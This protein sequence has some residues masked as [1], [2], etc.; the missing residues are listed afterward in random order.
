MK[1]SLDTRVQ[2]VELPGR[3]DQP[4]RPRST[5]LLGAQA[6]ATL[7]LTDLPAIRQLL[8]GVPAS[9]LVSPDGAQARLPYQLSWD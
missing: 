6:E 5:R 9:I 3:A 4:A 7:S 8:R 2:L 1:L